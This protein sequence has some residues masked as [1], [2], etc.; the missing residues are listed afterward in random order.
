M[1][2]ISTSSII[3]KLVHP[4]ISRL[5]S[6][7]VWSR[8]KNHLVMQKLDPVKISWII[9]AKENGMKNADVA[10]SMKISQCWVQKLY[11]RYHNSGEIPIL[12]KPGRPKRII[13]EEMKCI[14]QSAFEK[15]RCSAVFLEKIID[16]DGIHIPHNTIHQILRSKGLAEQQP[17]KR[18]RRKWIRFERTYSNSMWHT[19]WKLL[20]DGR[21]FLC[22]QDDASRFIISHGVFAEATTDNAILVL[23]EA[24]AKHGRPASI[25]TDHGSQFYANKSE[26][27]R[28]GASRFEQELVRLEIKHIMAR[29]NHPQTNGKLERFHGEI[30]RKQKWFGTIDELVE[31]YNYTKPHMSLDWDNLE[32]PA[33]AFVRKMPQ[34]GS[35]VIDEQTGEKYYAE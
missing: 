8:S 7:Y 1:Y 3:L 32:T 4:I 11:S 26:Y 9:R 10:S 13:T 14:V 27:K 28:K 19:D 34:K 2:Q 20:D 35:T 25:L 16:T 17:K 30:Q 23:R 24:I 29:V 15:F 18:R 12:R 21:W 31:W 6:R 5:K 22:Y 33:K